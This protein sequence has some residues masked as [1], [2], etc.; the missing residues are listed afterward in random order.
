M[1]K[2]RSSVVV[3]GGASG[4]GKALAFRFGKEGNDIIIGDVEEAALDITI[5]E[6]RSAG[7]LA[8]GIVV[9]VSDIDSVRSFKDRIFSEFT[10]LTSF[11]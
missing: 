8:T 2:D 3:T 1:I 7:I 10:P 9:D 4:I 6:L 11:A 5:S